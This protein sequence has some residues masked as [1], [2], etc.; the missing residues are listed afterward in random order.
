MV[1]AGHETPE[2]V[3]QHGNESSHAGTPLAALR[4]MRHEPGRPRGVEYRQQRLPEDSAQLAVIRMR[5]CA[6]QIQV[7]RS[8][9]E[10][11]LREADMDVVAGPIGM[12]NRRP[13]DG[14]RV[15][16]AMRQLGR[17]HSERHAVGRTRSFGQRERDVQE[18]PPPSQPD[19]PRGQV[20]AA[21]PVERAS[22]RLRLR[23]VHV[24]RQL[25]GILHFPV[26]RPHRIA[27]H[28]R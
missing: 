27:S 20:I 1:G 15:D 9:K 18:R 22:Q 13:R 10:G 19:E 23:F 17:D 26:M 14:M 11:D 4:D 28:G 7:D 16:P 5:L 6:G 12:A 25:P 24:A 21:A 2:Q 8:T 3:R